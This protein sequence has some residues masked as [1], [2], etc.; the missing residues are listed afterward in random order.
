MLLLTSS[1]IKLIYFEKIIPAKK[2]QS[3]F[4]NYGVITTFI[5]NF[6]LSKN[7]ETLFLNYVS[8][9]TLFFQYTDQFLYMNVWAQIE[10]HKHTLLHFLHQFRKIIHI[11]L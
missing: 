3:L 6:N 4:N 5:Y 9:I 8:G 1:L 2:V 7:I 11:T 10:L